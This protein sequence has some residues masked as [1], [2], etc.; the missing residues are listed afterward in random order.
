MNRL[1]GK[2]RNYFESFPPVSYEKD[3]ILIAKNELSKNIFYIV[4]GEVVQYGLGTASSRVIL[5]VYKP[6]AII[7]L[8]RIFINSH[9]KYY[10]STAK[11]TIYRVAP[12]EKVTKFI[13]QEPSVQADLIKRLTIGLDGIVDK[14]FIAYT[15]SAKQRVVLE[16][17]IMQS[18][19]N[20]SSGN[21]EIKVSHGEIAE[22]CGLT[23][24]T[25]TRILGK[26][27]KSGFIVKQSNKIAFL[28]MAELQKI[29]S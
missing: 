27:A 17:L 16:L 8:S 24:E 28:N 1:A 10:F 14:L 9:S 5:N 22:K 4:S 23:R 2:I 15:G 19:R 25:V 7:P 13:K 21:F 3:T 20:N 11:T 12:I 26:L 29:V 6:G 18:R